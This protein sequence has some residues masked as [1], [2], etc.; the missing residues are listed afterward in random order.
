MKI[1]KWIAILSIFFLSSCSRIPMRL[2]STAD[3]SMNFLMA[4]MVTH[5]VFLKPVMTDQYQI[6]EGQWCLT[7]QF[8]SNFY[9]SSMWEKQEYDWVRSELRPYIANCN[10]AR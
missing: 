2:N 8:G 1:V 3:Q 7:Y 6:A 10:W 9:F 5:E 4:E